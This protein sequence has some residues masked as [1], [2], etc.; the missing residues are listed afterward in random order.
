MLT[1]SYRFGPS[2]ST[3]LGSRGDELPWPLVGII[4]VFHLDH[5]TV[6]IKS[7]EVADI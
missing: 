4:A 7:D 2:L 3:P 5:E 1:T 6:I